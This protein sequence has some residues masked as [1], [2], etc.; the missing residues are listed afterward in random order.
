MNVR[1]ESQSNLL[2]KGLL[3]YS[4]HRSSV[5]LIVNGLRPEWLSTCLGSIRGLD[6]ATKADY[7]FFRKLRRYCEHFP[8]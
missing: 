3:L 1:V 4:S 5:N 2:S 6:C 7:L 8:F